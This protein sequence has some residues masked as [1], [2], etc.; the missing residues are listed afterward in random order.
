MSGRIHLHIGPRKTGTTYLQG[1][2]VARQDALRQ[3]GWTYPLG[4]MA[5]ERGLNHEWLLMGASSAEPGDRERLLRRGLAKAPGNVIL[6]GEALATLPEDRMA[7]L[8][9][10]LAGRE[11]HVVIT[12]RA[13]H[14][15]LPSLWQ[16]DVRNGRG[17]DFEEFL[18]RTLEPSASTRASRRVDEGSFEDFWQAYAL[19]PLIERW[20]GVAGRVSIV[21]VPA[22]DSSPTIAWERFL[23][24]LGLDDAQRAS[25]PAPE[26]VPRHP[27]LSLSEALVL[28]EINRR[29]RKAGMEREQR[30]AWSIQLVR[31][32]FATRTDRGQPLTVPAAL[33]EPLVERTRA[34]SEQLQAVLADERV[35][36]VGS[37]DD[38]Q[39][40]ELPPPAPDTALLAEEIAVLGG[41]C[42]AHLQ[43]VN[44]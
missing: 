29:L 8:V 25:V 3:L 23:T 27:S 4:A 28:R 20:L 32:V 37:I 16:Q 1:C 14:R 40:P 5:G 18:G 43:R 15:V 13:L 33:W 26:S 31:E 10:Q 36:L 42:I 22:V 9:A 44:R 7:R 41:R 2:L 21:T 34:E 19:A 6:S 11:T 24:A 30:R 35:Q 38:L 12:A 39:V 17:M